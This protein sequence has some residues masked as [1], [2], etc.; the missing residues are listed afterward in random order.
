MRATVW[1]LDVAHRARRLD[2]EVPEGVRAIE[3]VERAVKAE[4]GLELVLALGVR[5]P[6]SAPEL[7]YLVPAG[8]AR[9]DWPAL[10]D[11]ARSDEA[12]FALYVEAMLGGWVPPTRELDVFYFGNGPELAATLAHLV[13]K[14]VK[15]GTTGW[16]AAAR[17]DGVVLPEVGMVSIVTDGFGHAQCA[18]RWDKVEHLRFGDIDASHAWAEGEGDRTLAD[19]R[20][21]H[22]GYFGREATRLGLAFSDDEIVFFAHFSLISVLGRA[23][24]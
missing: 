5:A 8:G 12:G 17:R 23:D 11:W 14:S 24:G 10:P 1:I 21:G 19:W 2:C 16:L 4:L 9:N 3:A 22:L 7:L 13:V 18:I 15:R 20:A 6:D